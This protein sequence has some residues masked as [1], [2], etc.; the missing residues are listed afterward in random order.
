[1]ENILLFYV[2][3]VF[4]S[5]L[6]VLNTFCLISLI[7]L[8]SDWIW[9]DI[10]I[11]SFIWYI[12]IYH[13]IHIWY[14]YIFYLVL[15]W[16]LNCQDGIKVFGQHPCP[17]FPQMDSFLDRELFIVHIRDEFCKKLKLI[18]SVCCAR[19]IK[20][21]IDYFFPVYMD[22]QHS[23]LSCNRHWYANGIAMSLLCFLDVFP[24]KAVC[25]QR[26]NKKTCERDRPLQF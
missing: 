18:E 6:F 17:S 13:G 26:A 1:V 16:L 2:P 12:C 24:D 25:I 15:I 4:P 22:Y 11:R 8:R 20:V 14:V 10:W 21:S 7:S 23:C 19:P 3:E 5:F 9:L